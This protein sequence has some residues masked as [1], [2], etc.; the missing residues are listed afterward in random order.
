MDSRS[1]VD[2]LI[3]A[4][5]DHGAFLHW[6]A[7]HRHASQ[8]SH[9]AQF[10]WDLGLTGCWQPRGCLQLTYRGFNQARGLQPHIGYLCTACCQMQSHVVAVSTIER[11]VLQKLWKI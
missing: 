2:Y 9:T 10:C 6:P 4:D 1:V 11:L 3:G 8:S 7:S 5:F